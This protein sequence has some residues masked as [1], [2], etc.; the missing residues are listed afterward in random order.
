MSE[1]ERHLSRKEAA[2]FLTQSGYRTA[3]STLA[4]LACLGGGPTYRC[5][6]RKPLYTAGD[7]ITWAEARCSEPKRSTSDSASR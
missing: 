6:G 2:E 5:F 7:L 1:I 4:K 3:P